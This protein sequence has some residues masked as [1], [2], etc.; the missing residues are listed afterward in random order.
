MRIDIYIV[1]LID[2]NQCI[3][4]CASAIVRTRF[5]TKSKTKRIL[6]NVFINVCSLHWLKAA[7]LV[8]WLLWKSKKTCCVSL[9]EWNELTQWKLSSCL[10]LV[11]LCMCAALN[12]MT[13]IHRWRNCIIDSITSFTVYCVILFLLIM[14]LVGCCS[15]LK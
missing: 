3:L 15:V 11:S 2:M 7:L 13:C 12:E 8:S 1:E 14:Y 10:C 4:I 9:S 5:V 6:K